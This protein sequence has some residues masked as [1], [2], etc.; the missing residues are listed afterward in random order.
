MPLTKGLVE[1]HQG[2]LW[3]ESR[4]NAGTTFYLNLPIFEQ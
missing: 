4:E 3:V 2:E 1:K